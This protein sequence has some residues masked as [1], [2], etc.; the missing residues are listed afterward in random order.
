MVEYKYVLLTGSD[1]GDRHQNLKDALQQVSEKVG[2][3]IRGSSVI[4]TEPWGFES[5]TKFLNQAILVQSELEPIDLLGVILEI[6]KKIG[7]V[8]NGT[9]WTSRIIDIDILCS[10][11]KIFHS[12]ELVMP[13]E[14]LHER[15][16][17]LEPLCE[18][19]SWIHPLLKVSYSKILEQLRNDVSE[20]ETASR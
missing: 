10:E 9:Q 19:V 3:V 5:D 14:R 1:L 20:A 4:E 16:F 13:H 17:A 12:P 8:R 7:R 15:I 2:R 18:V 11:N 6:E